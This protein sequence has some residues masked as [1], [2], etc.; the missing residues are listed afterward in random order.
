[1]TNFEKAAALIADQQAK[2]SKSSAPWYVGEQLKDILRG[3]EAAAAIAEADLTQKGMGIA[4]CEK[5]IR[6]FARGNG[7]FCGPLDAERIIREFYGLGEKKIVSP[8]NAAA[9]RRTIS[10]TDFL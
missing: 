3:D 4:D 1:M 5:K 2:V 6:T 8:A 10:V 9:P 7:G